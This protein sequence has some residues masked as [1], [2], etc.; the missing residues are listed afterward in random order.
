MATIRGAD[1]SA[2]DAYI[3]AFQ[4]DVRSRLE[5]IRRT[6]REAAPDA[7][8]AMKYGI[9]TFVLHGNLVHYGGFKKHVGFYHG[10]TDV[11]AAFQGE[12]ASYKQ[13]KGTVQFPLDQPLPLDL[14][15][16]MTLARV[17]ENVEAAAARKK[18]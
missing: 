11:A 3:A 7:E 8:E 16:R 6:I 17:Q 1:A 9:P 13:S 14:I 18:R 4:D 5:E 12:L 2:V 10:A 15:R